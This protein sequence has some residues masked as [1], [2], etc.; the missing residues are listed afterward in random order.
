MCK[1][2][3]IVSSLFVFVLLSG[4]TSPCPKSVVSSAGGSWEIVGLNF[5]IPKSTPIPVSLGRFTYDPPD[6]TKISDAILALNEYNVAQCQAITAYDKLDPKPVDRIANLIDK[7][8]TANEKIL[9]IADGLKNAP[10][11]QAVLDTAA[12]SHPP[13]PTPVPSQN[14]TSPTA[15]YFPPREW[16]LTTE[17]RL[18]TLMSLV[19]KQDDTNSGDSPIQNTGFLDVVHNNRFVVTGFAK[20]KSTL[21][22]LMKKEI[23]NFFKQLSAA[24]PTA[25]ILTIALVGYTDTSGVYEKNIALGLSRAQAVANY[26]AQ[27]DLQSPS[28]VRFLS[29]AGVSSDFSRGRQVEIYVLSSTS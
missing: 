15:A 27:I 4:C 3:S 13:A 8:S 7:I 21:T 19:P 5:T 2:L 12:N 16:Y 17:N 24:M 10:S 14:P 23:S 22:E 6:V 9:A 18:H 25:H 20:G 1:L 29:S 26:M 28:R 11:K